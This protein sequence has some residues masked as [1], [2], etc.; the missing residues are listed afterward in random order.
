MKKE[1]P[2][3]TNRIVKKMNE[4][5]VFIQPNLKTYYIVTV[6]KTVWYKKRDR[7]TD[8]HTR[9]NRDPETESHKCNTVI[10]DKGTKAIQWEKNASSKCCWSNWT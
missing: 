9:Q 4:V 6:I 7:Y 8:T 3:I 2:Q 5:E 10:F 1:G